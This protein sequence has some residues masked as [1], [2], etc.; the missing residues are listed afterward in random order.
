MEI[1]IMRYYITEVEKQNK[2][3][4][5]RQYIFGVKAMAFKLW[6]MCQ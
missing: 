1:F 4:E 6:K 5:K 3:S 2:V